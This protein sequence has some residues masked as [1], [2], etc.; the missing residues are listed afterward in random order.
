MGLDIDYYSDVQIAVKTADLQATEENSEDS[1]KE[2]SDKEDSDE[3]DSD[4]ED[5]DDEDDENSYQCEQGRELVR[6]VQAPSKDGWNDGLED[7]YY[8]AVPAGSFS[9]GAYS[10]H[11]RF[12][13]ELL[14]LGG[15]TPIPNWKPK[16]L[17]DILGGPLMRY[18]VEWE[19]PFAFLV[20]FADNEGYIGPLSSETL[21]DDFTCYRELFMKSKPESGFV[22]LYD[23]WTEAFGIAS[24]TG[25]VVVFH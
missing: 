20:H 21:H 24:K 8:T 22:D 13:L 10:K 11:M 7:G 17:D 19:K 18:N 4:E 5:S 23:E 1:D 14:K 3:E 12:R 16:T 2:D 9:V 25:G 6:L 15:H